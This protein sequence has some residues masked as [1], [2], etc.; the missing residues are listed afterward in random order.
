MVSLIASLI[1]SLI[2]NPMA[3]LM[4]SLILS[5]TVSL[6]MKHSSTD[7]S[8]V[9]QSPI[10]IHRHCHAQASVQLNDGGAHLMTQLK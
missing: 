6:M 3:S 7:C 1:A 10:A 2:V 4:A 9:A 8:R 5:L